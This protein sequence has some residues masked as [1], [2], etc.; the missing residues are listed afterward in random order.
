MISVDIAVGLLRIT[1]CKV[2]TQKTQKVWERILSLYSYEQNDRTICETVS[3][4]DGLRL[5][6][7][8]QPHISKHN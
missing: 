1:R 2:D 7:K 5:L 8:A 3:F 4:V 6:N